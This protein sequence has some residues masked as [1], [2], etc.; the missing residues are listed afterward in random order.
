MLSTLMAILKVVMNE[1][2]VVSLFLKSYNQEEIHNYLTLCN[3]KI[4]CSSLKIPYIC[5]KIVKVFF[6][7]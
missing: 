6:K 7:P 5:I 3:A 4:Y 2:T 1:G